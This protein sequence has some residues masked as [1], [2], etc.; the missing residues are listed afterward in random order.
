MLYG[1]ECWAVDKKM[2]QKMSNWHDNVKMV[3]IW[4]Y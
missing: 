1:L 3:D 2:E 4:S